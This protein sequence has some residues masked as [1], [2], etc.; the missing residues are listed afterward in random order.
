MQKDR[1]YQ[2]YVGSIKIEN[3]MIVELEDY[4]ENKWYVCPDSVLNSCNLSDWRYREDVYPYLHIVGDN[5]HFTTYF[6]Y[7]KLRYLMCFQYGYY[8]YYECGQVNNNKTYKFIYDTNTFDCFMQETDECWHASL[9]DI[10]VDQS[11]V[12][13]DSISC[14]N[15]SYCQHRFEKEYRLVVRQRY[16]IFQILRLKRKFKNYF[17][18]DH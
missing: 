5:P 11:Y 18:R 12:F 10:D 8:P 16:N 13:M 3:P 7:K 4:G 6:P 9:Y 2:Y 1:Y 17:N 15:S 14:N